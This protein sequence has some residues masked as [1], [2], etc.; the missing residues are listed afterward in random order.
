MLGLEHREYEEEEHKMGFE[1]RQ[2]SSR[3]RPYKLGEGAQN[4]FSWL[5]GIWKIVA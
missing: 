2:G 5:R 1:G 3:R 4:V